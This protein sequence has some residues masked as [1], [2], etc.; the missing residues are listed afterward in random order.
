MDNWYYNAK[1]DFRYRLI[2]NQW[3]KEDTEFR[4]QWGICHDNQGRLVY[5]YNWSQLHMDLVPPNYLSANPNH[6]PTSGIDYALSMDRQIFPIRTNPA[7]NRG[8]IEGTLDENGRLIEF[9]SACAPYIYRGD[10]FDPKMIGNAFVCEPTGNLIKENNI[11]QDGIYP[12]AEYAYNQSEFLASSDERFRPVWLT[13]GP[14][15]ALYVADM[16]RGIIQHGIYMSDYLR[17]TTI[18]RKLDQHINLGR[19]WRV[20]PDK[21]DGSANSQPGLSAVP[22]E[23]L[24]NLLSHPNGWYRDKAQQLLVEKQ[25]LRAIDLLR[26]ELTENPDQLMRLHAL[27]TLEG[28]SYDQSDIFLKALQD[29]SVPVKLAALRILEPLAK[30]DER[31]RKQLQKVL[32][33][34]ND[35]EYALQMTLSA[36]VLD[37][38]F[39]HQLISKILQQFVHAPV[40]RDAAMSSIGNEENE[41]LQRILTQSEWQ[42]HTD[43]KEIFIE[44]L[45]TAIATKRDHRELLAMLEILETANP[46]WQQQA[47]ITGLSFFSPSENGEQVVLKVEP[48]LFTRKYD[49]EM[50]SKLLRVSHLFTWPGKTVEIKIL[51]DSIDQA[52]PEVLAQGRNVYLSICANCHGNNGKGLKRFAPPLVSSEWVLGNPEILTRIL[53]HGMEGPLTVNGKVYDT[54]EILPVMPAFNSTPQSEL[55]AVM[56]YIRQE[57]GNKANPIESSM[58]GGLR[59]VNQGKV[60]PWTQEELIEYQTSVLD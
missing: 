46:G 49:D 14:D 21:Q 56:T 43:N 25:D 50:S 11:H 30:K 32:Q 31:L 40:F 29:E 47:I 16:Y 38:K 45:A 24:V 18:E 54:P 36:R 42:T 4:G 6:Q 1:A 41:F 44:Q 10:L 33:A 8:Y 39:K 26:V 52:S 2:N 28:L 17:E 60:T 27:W 13:S 55:A 59:V 12:T 48:E 22:I 19:I 3:I 5:N 34:P 58:V 15:G 9:T 53:L 23:K 35:M 57:W 20:S 37:R 7:I 51:S